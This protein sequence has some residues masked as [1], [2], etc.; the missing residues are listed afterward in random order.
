M[1]KSSINAIVMAMKSMELKNAIVV[2][3]KK[4]LPK[5]ESEGIMKTRLGSSAHQRRSSKCSLQ[6]KTKMESFP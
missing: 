3:G 4:H 2:V 5:A 1:L 6:S